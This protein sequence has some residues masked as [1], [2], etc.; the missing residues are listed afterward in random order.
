[1]KIKDKERVRR[2]RI[3]YPLDKH[4]DIEIVEEL[5]KVRKEKKYL[6]GWIERQAG[7]NLNYC[8]NGQK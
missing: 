5:N 4:T 3:A 2:Y 1:M 7:I 8:F 6:D